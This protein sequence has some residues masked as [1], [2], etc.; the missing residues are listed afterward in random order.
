MSDRRPSSTKLR[1]EVFDRYKYTCELT[2]RIK[3]DCIRCALPIDPARDP[4]EA[5]HI[6]RRVLSGDDDIE[7]LAPMHEHCH[8]EKTKVDV[9][10]N[11]KGKRIH[12]RHFK[13]EVKRKRQW[14]PA[15]AKFDWSTGRYK[16]SA[17]ADE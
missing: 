11:A 8:R 5:D 6:I 13:I 10:E 9:S 17:E 16:M 1:R 7:N 3:M 15:G 12:N 4:W 14:R 2:G